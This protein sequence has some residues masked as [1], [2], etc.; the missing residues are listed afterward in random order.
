MHEKACTEIAKHLRKL[1]GE[2]ISTMALDGD[3]TVEQFE[4]HLTKREQI[5]LKI[6]DKMFD[7][8]LLDLSCTDLTS[9][10]GKLFT[11]ITSTKAAWS[12]KIADEFLQQGVS[13]E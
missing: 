3:I 13:V 11:A 5:A 12:F 1:F 6:F 9:E 2:H 10:E 8:N 7:D 4:E